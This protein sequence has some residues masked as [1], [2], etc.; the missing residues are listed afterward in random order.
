MA[1]QELLVS[2]RSAISVGPG[3]NAL[4]HQPEFPDECPV[5]RHGAIQASAVRRMTEGSSARKSI[6]I[7]S[8][9]L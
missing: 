9:P 4:P 7:S 3:Y 8:S 2:L 5:G 6:L 1:R